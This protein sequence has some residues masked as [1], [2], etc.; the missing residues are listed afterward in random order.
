MGNGLCR[1]RRL[2]FPDERT[3]GFQPSDSNHLF[4]S[5]ILG[6]FVFIGKELN[7]G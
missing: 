4:G 3:L 5:N 1:R 6:T 7:Q 2:E